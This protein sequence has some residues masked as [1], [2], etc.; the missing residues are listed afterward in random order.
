MSTLLNLKLLMRSLFL[1]WRSFT[2]WSIGF[3][4]SLLFIPLDIFIW[5][6]A[7]FSIYRNFHWFFLGS[8]IFWILFHFHKY[9]SSLFSKNSIS[10]L[11]G[12]SFKI[13]ALIT[14]FF[15]QICD[16]LS[17]L[18]S[19]LFGSFFLCQLNFSLIC[20]GFCFKNIYFFFY[21]FLFSLQLLFISLFNFFRRSFFF[22]TFLFI[23]ASFLFSSFLFLFFLSLFL[24]SCSFSFFFF[25]S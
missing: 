7:C 12:S 10:E 3:G 6:P 9:V 17:F 14:N 16:F 4:V 11:S 2:F 24:L 23:L 15:N 18:F 25:L 22:F 1:F 19:I 13:L 20:L 8:F 5:G 21:F